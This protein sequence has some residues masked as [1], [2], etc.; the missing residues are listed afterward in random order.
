MTILSISF[1]I[2]V[3]FLLFFYYLLPQKYQWPLLLLA[4]FL[5]Y[6]SAGNPFTSVFLLFSIVSTYLGGILVEKKGRYKGLFFALTVF[7]NLGI[8]IVLKYTD[9]ILSSFGFS[10]SPSRFS[11][12]L[13]LGLSFYTFQVIGYM[14]D[15][16][17]G[18]IPPERN[19]GKYA[20]FCC[21]FPQIT[22]GPIGRFGELA[23]SLFSYKTFNMDNVKSGFIRLL[24]GYFKKMVISERLG[25]FVDVV[26]SSYASYNS[27][28]IFV[29]AVFYAIQLYTD[30]SGYMDIVLGIS[31]MLGITMAENFHSPFFS[32]TISEFWRRWHMTLGSFLRD[33]LFFPLLKSKPFLWLSEKVKRTYGK[34]AGKKIP[35]Y[36]AMF[37][38]WF[39][40]G[41]WHGPD[42]KYVFGVGIFQWICIVLGEICSPLSKNIRTFT[43]Y[44]LF[45]QVR[46]FLLICFS[47]LFFRSD[48]FQDALFMLQRCFSFSGGQWALSI[49]APW[50]GVALLI[51]IS[52]LFYLDTISQKKDI[53]QQYLKKPAAIQYCI[54]YFLIFF[55]LIFGVFGLGFDSSAFTY[56]NF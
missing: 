6:L 34:K 4:S 39:S 17:R 45:C 11:F 56:A 33:Y 25:I 26:F 36:L 9:F 7:S 22:S 51:S 24:Y 12:F 50:E 1:F 31:R 2:F 15:V 40:V 35:T 54:Y 16:Y 5:F 32:S 46:T 18:L 10:L 23:P 29:G 27:A 20:L 37:L 53:W 42:W 49:Y 21:F 48:S 30:F 47:F 38:L 41:L 28:S 19:I 13:P 52:I 55:I 3:F 8:L 43:I 14:T 44:P